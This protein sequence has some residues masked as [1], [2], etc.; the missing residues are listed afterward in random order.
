MTKDG[1]GTES[2]C[3][4]SEATSATEE[5]SVS[6]NSREI[7]SASKGECVSLMPVRGAASGSVVDVDVELAVLS[8]GA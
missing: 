6:S 1:S 7:S 5:P 3:A 4:F 8:T 2:S